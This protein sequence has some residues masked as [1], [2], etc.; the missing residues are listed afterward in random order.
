MRVIVTNP[1]NIFLICSLAVSAHNLYL[2]LLQAT[3]CMWT[4]CTLS[5]SRKWPSWPHPWLRHPCRAAWPSTT[6]E[7][8][9]GETCSQCS[10]ETSWATTRRSGGQ[11]CMRPLAGLWSALTS[12]PRTPWRSV[13][14]LACSITVSVSFISWLEG[15][16]WMNE[17]TVSFYFITNWVFLELVAEGHAY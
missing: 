12:K 10:P 11:R 3:T 16:E 13:L 2:P 1:L 7:T 8:R 5:I 6:T 4:L 17:F 14:E 15:H 9:R